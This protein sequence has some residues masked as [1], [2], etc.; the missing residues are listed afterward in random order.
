MEASKLKDILEQHKLWIDGKGGKCATLWGANLW[1]ANLEGANLYRANLRGANL[2]GANLGG[3]NL[4]GAYLYRADLEGANLTGANLTDANL[5]GADLYI[6]NLKDANLKDAN[7]KDANLTGANLTGANLYRAN[8]DGANLNRADLTNTTL[9]DI[10]WIIPGCLAQLNNIKY[11]GFYLEKEVKYENFIQDSI[12]F[13]IQDNVEEKTFDMLVGDRI[14]RNIPDWVKYS[15]LRQVA[16]E[17]VD[18]L[19]QKQ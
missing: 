10:S 19:R 5:T 7:L 11:L 16:T 14:I 6:A 13:F 3:A 15:G 9:P 1:G 8:L 2:Q 12:G 4:S 17:S 18:F